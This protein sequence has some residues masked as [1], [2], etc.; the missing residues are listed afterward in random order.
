MRHDA[1]GHFSAP[2]WLT[3]T[4]RFP[5]ATAGRRRGDEG[6]TVKTGGRNPAQVK[7]QG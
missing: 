6:L 3:A 2:L 7:V 1:N 5:D 4:S